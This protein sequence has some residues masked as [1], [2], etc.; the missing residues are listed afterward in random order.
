MNEQN[1]EN[2]SAPSENG[3]QGA[4]DPILAVKRRL[5]AAAL[6]HVPF[7]GWSDS[8][9]SQAVSDAEVDP[10]EAK[11]AFPRGGVDMAM[12][13]HRE[14]DR[15]LKNRMAHADLPSMRV[16]ERVAFAVR[17]RLEIAEEHREAVRKGAALFALPLYASDGARAV[18][19]TSDVIWTA[20]GDPSEDLNWYTKRMILS[21]VYGSTSL[22]WLGDETPNREAT[23]AFLDR[24]I[25][26]VM[27]FEKMK[28]AVNSNPLGRM[29]MMGPNWVA[30][31]IRKPGSGHYS[32][33]APIDLPGGG[34]PNSG[35]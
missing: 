34:F 10:Y 26:G 22:Y 14:G 16:R 18:W 1:A 7:D 25:E 3:D 2:T 23:W 29:M 9:L 19:E 27:Q 35:S 30:G 17:T 20:L 24:R 31:K 21:G 32:S 15:E 11:L 5:L 28:S 6:P 12:F 4:E 33:G 8:A 13:F